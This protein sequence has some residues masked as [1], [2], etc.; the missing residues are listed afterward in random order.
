[1]I[2][3]ITKLEKFT[4]ISFQVCKNIFMKWLFLPSR[5]MDMKDGIQSML[6]E[7]Y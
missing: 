3:I 6:Q 5:T 2:E 4:E 1:M 7:R